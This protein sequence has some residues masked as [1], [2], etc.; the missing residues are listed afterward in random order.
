MQE[1][2]ESHLELS[3]QALVKN[4]TLVPTVQHFMSTIYLCIKMKIQ[5]YLSFTVKVVLVAKVFSWKSPTR[6]YGK[7]A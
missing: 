7:K 1:N 4:T 2:K 5:Q 6:C 3:K